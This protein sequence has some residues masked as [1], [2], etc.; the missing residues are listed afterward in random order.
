MGSHNLPKIGGPYRCFKKN[1]RGY[2]NQ[3]SSENVSHKVMHRGIVFWFIFVCESSSHLCIQ[4]LQI[5][6]NSI[7]YVVDGSTLLG[8]DTVVMV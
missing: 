4:T 8:A 1:P 6:V 7:F 3:F 5:N 2:Q